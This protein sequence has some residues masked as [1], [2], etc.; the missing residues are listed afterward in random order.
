MSNAHKPL[1]PGVASTA[2]P[3]ATCND[4]VGMDR[5][6]FLAGAVRA[7][8]GLTLAGL[9]HTLSACSRPAPRQ[10]PNLVKDPRG[11]CDLPAGFAYTVISRV[12][13]TMSD[14]HSVPDY[15]DGMGC[16][17]GPDGSILL[18]RNHEI[19]T[20]F[21]FDPPSPAPAFAY[22]P[23]ASGGTTTIRLNARLEVERHY[24]SLT[25]TIRN[26][27]GGKTPWGTWL[28]CEEAARE[29]WSMG[30]R[31]GYVFEVDPLQPLRRAL[32]L[33]AMGRFNHEAVAIDP[34]SGIAYQTED[35]Y[36]GC[37]YRYLPRVPGRL[38][39]GGTLEALKFVDPAIRHTSDDGLEPGRAYACA[40]VR[41]DEPDPEEDNVHLQGQSKGAAIFVR[42]EGM[43]AHPD[44][45]YFVCSA[46]G[47]A[48]L[49]QIFRYR[50]GTDAASGEIELVYTAEA[51]S[52]LRKPDNLTVAPWGDLILCE[53]SGRNENCLAGFTANGGE[54][55]IA[56][57]TQSEWCGACFSPDGRTLFA[58]IHKKPGM[59]LAIR[60]PWASLRP[61]LAG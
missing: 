3:A 14:G 22:D 33:T 23:A 40:W 13:E 9:L 57:N 39:R 24:L 44:G 32:P 59:T 19:S 8:A 45:I 56:A 5:R 27:S 1:Y 47:K 6:R 18:V 12:G 49:G 35:A 46:G 41:I 50:P 36:E 61:G 20:Y 53:D 60:G 15:H 31:H 16:F 4:H 7:G 29:G 26:C 28:S 43:V 58:N 21:P 10:L 51:T 52:L 2:I 42:G 48:G 37:F 17:D 55:L 34:R 54:Y 11:L 38:D 25:G 30:K